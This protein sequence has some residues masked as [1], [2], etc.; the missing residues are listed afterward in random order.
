M[1]ILKFL[2]KLLAVLLFLFFLS[3]LIFPKIKY[4]TTQQINLSIDKTFD[5]YT[6]TK[7]MKDWYVGLQSIRTEEQKPGVVGNKYKLVTDVQGNFLQLKRIV[8]KYK[9]SEK[10]HYRTQSV[11]MIKEEAV[12]FQN[13]DAHSFGIG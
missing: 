2:F 10:I 1:R 8:T 12:T 5:L 3:G 6:D 4:T 13:I 11:E 7:K 9:Q